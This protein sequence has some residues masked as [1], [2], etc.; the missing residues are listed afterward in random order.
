LHWSDGTDLGVLD[1]LVAAGHASKDL[2]TGAVV[3]DCIGMMCL[4]CHA[5]LRVIVL[6]AVV[7]SLLFSQNKLSGIPT[8]GYRTSCPACGERWTAS[9]LE[10][11]GPEGIHPEQEHR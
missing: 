6:E 7:T 8:H 4:K 3:G 5:D 9:V 10:F 2:F 1:E 11:V